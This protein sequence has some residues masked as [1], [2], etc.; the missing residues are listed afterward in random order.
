M[1]TAGPPRRGGPGPPDLFAEAAA[2]Q[3]R[4]RAPP[5]GAAAAPDPGH[6][7]VGQATWWRPRLPAR[8]LIEADRL[9]S[10]IL[11]GPA[12]TGKTTLA[13]VVAATTAKTFVPLSAVN[14]GVADVRAAIRRRPPP[15]R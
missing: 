5:G 7:I 4:Q 6:D 13:R 9:T 2:E 1:P 14:A 10:A 12:G 15:A 8:V 11:W 3:F